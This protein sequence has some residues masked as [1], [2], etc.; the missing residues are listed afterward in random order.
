MTDKP[1]APTIR[2]RYEETDQMGV[3]YH[4]NYLKYFD[5]GR[6]ELMRHLGFPYSEM[7]RRGVMLVVVEAH[8]RYRDSA[9]Y[10]D[11]LRIETAGTCPSPLRVRFHYRAVREADGV[12]VADGW[13]DLTCLDADRRLRRLPS[14]V[15]EGLERFELSV[16]E[17]V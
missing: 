4:G 5:V 16:E 1:F 8:C 10:D 14:E 15:R 7:E 3:V 12:V 2:V 9:R 11:V 13:S 17:L 6:T